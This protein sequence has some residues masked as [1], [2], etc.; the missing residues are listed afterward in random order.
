MVYN[1]IHFI[2]ILK[3]TYN[4]LFDLL[5]FCF[6]GNILLLLTNTCKVSLL[7]GTAYV[8]QDD[9]ALTLFYH[10]L[11][12]CTVFLSYVFS[13]GMLNLGLDENPFHIHYI[14]TVSDLKVFIFQ[15]C[16]SEYI[17]VYLYEFSCA[18]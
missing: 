2:W 18:Q 4:N 7:Y 13:Y 1:S 10:I 9:I 5:E 16:G 3:M 12:T 15:W 17:F 6:G 11:Y 8:V 14:Q